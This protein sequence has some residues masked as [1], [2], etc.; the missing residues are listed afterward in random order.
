MVKT[1]RVSEDNHARFR[2]FQH[3]V[4]A[5]SADEAMDLL[6]GDDA[7]H[8][9]MPK[10]VMTR[11]EAEAEDAGFPLDQWVAQRVEAYLANRAYAGEVRQA[12]DEL[13][14]YRRAMETAAMAYDIHQGLPPKKPAATG[15]YTPCTSCTT[16]AS[17][18]RGGQ[19]PAAC[20]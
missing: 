4:H 1:I 13:L 6:L 9:P 8:I 19:D 3:T 10:E 5:D 18:E 7:M 15:T 14:G 2:A 17:C 11:W 20:E 12:L 16:P